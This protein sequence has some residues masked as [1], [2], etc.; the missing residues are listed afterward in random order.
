MYVYVTLCRVRI[1]ASVPGAHTGKNMH[2]WGH[3]K[4]RKVSLTL[5][6]DYPLAVEMILTA[7]CLPSGVNGKFDGLMD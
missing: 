3:M 7:N 1:I 2:K 5:A 4:L 6:V